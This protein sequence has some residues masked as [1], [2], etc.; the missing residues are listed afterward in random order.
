MYDTIDRD[1]F[2]KQMELAE[3][4][5][6]V[7]E[8]TIRKFYQWMYSDIDGVVQ[9]CAFGVPVESDGETV[10]PKSKFEHVTTEDEF[11]DFAKQ[12]SGLWTYHV[13]S[14]VNVLDATPTDGRGGIEHIDTV[15]HVTFDIETKRS[16][17]QGST[18]EEVWWSYQYAMA[19]VQFVYQEYGVL[20]MVVMSENGIHMH[21]KADFPITKDLLVEKQ[22]K[23]SKFITQQ[24][25]N[26]DLVQE[27]KAAAPDGIEFDQDDVSD[28]ARVM[29]VPG[30]M[31]QKSEK[32]RMCAIIHIPSVGE[33]GQITTSD[34]SIPKAAV[35]EKPNNEKPTVTKADVSLDSDNSIPSDLGETIASHARNDGKLRALL[36]GDTLSYK[37]RSEAEFALI[38]K[39]LSIGTAPSDIPTVM[40]KSGMTKWGEDSEHYREKSLERALDY[41]DG[42]VYRDSSSSQMNFRRFSK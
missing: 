32:G 36:S 20:P 24:A 15:N 14:G 23:L 6:G 37:S 13:Y 3:A 4:Q 40:N 21:Y 35:L 31:G 34:I 27:V 11:V 1:T 33:A 17:Y 7:S 16:A 9:A 22:H 8:A 2:T 19:Q 18:V 12:Y 5:T 29:K 25:M 10:T 26:C 42:T 41:F 28:P 30:T 39:L 38:V